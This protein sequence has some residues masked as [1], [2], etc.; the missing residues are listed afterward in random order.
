MDASLGIC[1]ATLLPDPMGAT[2]DEQVRDAAGAAVDAG[3]TEASVWAHQLALV[4][5]SGLRVAVVEA[6]MAWATGTV[7]AAAAEAGYF[8]ATAESVGASKIVAVCMDADWPGIDPAREKLALLV[9]AAS[10]VGAQVCVEFLPW[11]PIPD[12]ATAWALVEPLGP[13]AGILVDSWH[14]QRQP[15][16]PCP[17]LLATIPAERIGYLQLCDAAATPSGDPL[18]EAM[19]NRLLP[20][21]GVVDFGA[22]VAQLDGMGATPFVATEIFNPAMVTAR[23]VLDTARAMRRSGLSVLSA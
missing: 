18:T 11:S 15:G 5:G 2:T 22:L 9:D 12:L 23:G 4:E 1:T 17:E 16:G 10:S 13:A 19:T 3:F 14:W 7:E 21:E 8:A 6:S 20:G